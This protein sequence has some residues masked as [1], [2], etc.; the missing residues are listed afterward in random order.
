MFAPTYFTPS[1]FTE[2][3]FPPGLEEEVVE[4][5]GISGVTGALIGPG[6]GIWPEEEVKDQYNR[7]LQDIIDIITI[8][9][10]SHII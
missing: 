2:R 3:Y 1:F 8:M 6:P 7:D 10:K 5:P 9:V 4:A